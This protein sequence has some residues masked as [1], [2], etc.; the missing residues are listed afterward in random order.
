MYECLLCTI[1]L[2]SLKCLMDHHSSS[3]PRD[4][5]TLNNKQHLQVCD[6]GILISGRW[7]MTR[8][9]ILICLLGLSFQKIRIFF[10][11]IANDQHTHGM[12]I[13]SLRKMRSTYYTFPPNQTD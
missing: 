8:I 3:F 11:F 13:Y 2:T 7:I 6:E 1:I 12:Q 9:A 5:L 10:N 4:C